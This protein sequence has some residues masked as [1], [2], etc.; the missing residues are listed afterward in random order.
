MSNAQYLGRTTAGTPAR[1]R[2]Q[3]REVVAVIAFSAVTASCLALGMLLLI[4]LGR[5]G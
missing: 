4:N 2:D 5:Q 3:A 1:V